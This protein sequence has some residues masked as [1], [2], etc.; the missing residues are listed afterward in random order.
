MSPAGGSDRLDLHIRHKSYRVTSGG[1]LHVLGEISFTLANGEVAAVVGSYAYNA[2][3]SLGAAAVVAPLRIADAAQ[4]HAP[5]LAML[6]ALVLVLALSA[7]TGHIDR[8][9]AVVLLAGYAVFSAI[10]V[11]S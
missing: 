8:R 9:D 2:T 6:G 4:V 5:M 11:A 3:M 1:R 10:S 7:R